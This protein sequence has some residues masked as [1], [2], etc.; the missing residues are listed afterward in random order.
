M[1]QLELE[2]GLGSPLHMQGKVLRGLIDIVG[3]GITPAYAGKKSPMK[4]KGR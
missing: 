4:N 2:R 3:V 1:F